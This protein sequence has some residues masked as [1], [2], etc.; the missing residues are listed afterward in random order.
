MRPVLIGLL[1]FAVGVGIFFAARAIFGGDDEAGAPAGSAEAGYTLD[2]PEGWTQL[3]ENQIAVFPNAPLA[4][5]ERE[6]DSGLFIVRHEDKPTDTSGNF[7]QQLETQLRG[8]V[9][10]YVEGSVKVLQTEAGP[11]FYFSYAREDSGTAHSIVLV[12]DGSSTFVLESASAS[13][14]RGAAEEIAAM[15]QSFDLQ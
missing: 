11:A 6:G 12:P 8:R 15:I 13:N 9:P 3:S 14:D 1:V 7:A 2:V 5:L 10:D 4:V